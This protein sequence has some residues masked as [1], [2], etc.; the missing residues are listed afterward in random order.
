MVLPLKIL[1]CCADYEG[2]ISGSWRPNIWGWAVAHMVWSGFNNCRKGDYKGREKWFCFI[3]S[4]TCSNWGAHFESPHTSYSLG[5]V[6]LLN[7]DLYPQGSC[8][9]VVVWGWIMC[10]KFFVSSLYHYSISMLCFLWKGTLLHLQ[11]T[12]RLNFSQFWQPLLRWFAPAFYKALGFI[13]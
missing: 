3:C 12:Q 4:S 7:L 6:F 5:Q 1:E 8:F 11:W 10:R 2:W 9:F 13:K